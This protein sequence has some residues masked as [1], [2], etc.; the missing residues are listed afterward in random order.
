MKD[1]AK[2]VIKEM[3]SAYMIYGYSFKFFIEQ[4]YSISKLFTTEELKE[5]WKNV[6]NKLGSEF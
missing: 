2:L 4:D 6:K 1:K 3:F 5:I